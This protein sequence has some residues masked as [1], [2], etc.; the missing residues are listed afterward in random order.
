MARKDSLPASFL[1][2]AIIFA[3][4]TTGDGTRSN[5]GWRCH[6]CRPGYFVAQQCTAMFGTQCA[7]CP[8]GTYTDYFNTLYRCKPCSS[9][10]LGHRLQVPCNREHDIKCIL[11]TLLEHLHG[12]P[13]YQGDEPAKSD[14]SVTQPA[15]EDGS[16]ELT[17]QKGS[18][19]SNI[20]SNENGGQNKFFDIPGLSKIPKNLGEPYQEELSGDS[21]IK[22][23]LFGMNSFETHVIRINKSAEVP[24]IRPTLF[25][26]GIPEEA[27]TTVVLPDKEAH[28]DHLLP[29][30]ETKDEANVMTSTIDN[31]IE[32]SAMSTITPEEHIK[33]TAGIPIQPKMADSEIQNPA[34][35]QPEMVESELSTSNPIQVGITENGAPISVTNQAE[36]E[37][38]LLTQS[39]VR[40]LPQ[41][42]NGRAKALVDTFSDIE[43]SIK[44]SV[45]RFDLSAAVDPITAETTTTFSSSV[46]QAFTD[47]AEATIS[48]QVEITSTSGQIATDPVI[49]ESEEAGSETDN[50]G[51]TETDIPHLVTEGGTADPSLPSSSTLVPDVEDNIDGA[52]AETTSTVPLKKMIVPFV[53]TMDEEAAT[54]SNKTPV[55]RIIPLEGVD[56]DEPLHV[57]SVATEVESSSKEIESIPSDEDTDVPVLTTPEQTYPM[58][59]GSELLQEPAADTASTE[60]HRHMDI[61][62]A[63]VITGIG[64]I[65]LAVLAIRYFVKKRTFKDMRVSSSCF[66]QPLSSL[67][68]QGSRLF[69]ATGRGAVPGPSGTAGYQPTPST[70]SAWP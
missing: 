12:T 56:E 46:A 69:S 1:L 47:V 42:Y 26:F 50:L 27:T 5:I 32:G 7:R 35:I 34:E 51:T 13:D 59:N 4:T 29:L 16:G 31:A 8:A 10:P 23:H 9:C 11:S 30:Q 57:T 24:T 21:P 6:T 40:L 22:P 2:S 65:V 17:E 18:Q 52:E 60:G 37:S 25:T 67:A 41:I 63:V 54:A 45:P 64:L 44:Q 39:P 36:V 48:T 3:L 49:P 15:I 20:F 68:S 43:G 19:F 38:P 66:A 55:A 14:D 70:N 58:G 28:I 53:E 33:T 61:V 62:I